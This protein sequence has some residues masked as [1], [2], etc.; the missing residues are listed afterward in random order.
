MKIIF[1]AIL[2]LVSA[3]SQQSAAG[4]FGKHS[5]RYM[6]F[7]TALYNYYGCKVWEDGHCAECADR[8]IFNDEGIC[9]EVPPTCKQ[10]NRAVGICERCYFGYQIYNG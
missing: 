5:P 3:R 10:F 9:K 1:L 7:M 4:S 8:Y 6:G 2:L